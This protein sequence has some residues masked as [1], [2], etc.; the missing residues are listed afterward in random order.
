MRPRKSSSKAT[1]SKAVLFDA[2][3]ETLSLGVL[4]SV[5]KDGELKIRT[6][7]GRL[8]QMLGIEGADLTGRPEIEFWNLLIPRLA[9]SQAVRGDLERLF[10]SQREQRTD[11]LTILQP[12]F[13]VVERSSAPLL[14]RKGEFVG[15]LWTFRNV[16]HEFVM[17]E[18]LQRKRKSEYCFRSLSSFLFEAQRSPESFSEICRIIA[19]GID[20]PSVLL[21]PVQLSS[22][23]PAQFAVGRRYLLAGAPEGLG[24]LVHDLGYGEDGIGDFLTAALDPLLSP[25][26]CDR[27]IRRIRTLPVELGGTIH[28]VLV[29]EDRESIRVWGPDELRSVVAA[30]RAVALWLQKEGDRVRLIHAREAAEAAAR[31]RTD[32]LALLSHELRTP[33]NPLI[34]FTQLLAE[35]R[36]TLPEAAQDMVARISSG[37]MRLKELVEDLL[38]LT[39][40]DNRVEGWRLYP[41]DPSGIVADACTWAGELG[42]ERNVAVE[43]RSSGTIGIVQA[44]GASLRRAFRA[45]LSNAVRFSPDGGTVTVELS[46]PR[47]DLVVRVRDRGPGVRDEAKERIFEAFVQEEPVLTR[48]FGGAG[49]GLTLVRRVAEAHHG[50]VWVEDNPGGGSVFHFQIP[51]TGCND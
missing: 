27:S 50:R 37:A 43:A 11:I 15:R 17:R 35:Q 4:L 24:L 47:S 18:E 28:A 49:I 8:Q 33:L 48:R 19:Q 46:F 5:V 9:N 36:D 21:L 10:A 51:V 38:T 12:E 32:F 16:T 13:S 44:D 22:D 26:F 42:A 7:S 1:I 40:L 45:L 20:L 3:L 29:L 25:V 14:D 6:L 31:V 34:G 2:T 39:R 23:R 41:C 30:A